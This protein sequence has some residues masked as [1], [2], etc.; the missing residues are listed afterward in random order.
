MP[1]E[2]APDAIRQLRDDCLERIRGGEPTASVL[3]DLARAVDAVVGEGGAASILFLDDAARLRNGAA[4]RLPRYYVEAIDGIAPDPAVGT[5]AAA[6]ATGEEV[7]TPSFMECDRWRELGHL[8]LALGYVGAWSHPIRSAVN[9]RVLGTFGVYHRDV[10]GPTDRERAIVQEL[11]MVAA[12]ALERR[13]CMAPA[14]ENAA[15]TD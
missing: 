1:H 3:H 14:G 15:P 4:P 13:T 6:A 10:R 8:P 12:C 11:A 2:S 9:Q 5:C 7:V